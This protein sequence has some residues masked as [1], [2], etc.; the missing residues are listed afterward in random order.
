LYSGAELRLACEWLGITLLHARP[1]DAPA[2]GKTE[3][4]YADVAIMQRPFMWLPR[5]AEDCGN[6]HGNGPHNVR[7]EV[8]KDNDGS[9][10]SGYV[11]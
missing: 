2:R 8:G 9:E 3:R 6:L 11:S 1:Y 4:F 10:K 5:L 7:I